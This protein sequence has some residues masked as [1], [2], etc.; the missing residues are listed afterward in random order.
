MAAHGRGGRGVLHDV[1]Q[2]GAGAGQQADGHQR[3]QRVVHRTAGR[4]P[5]GEGTRGLAGQGCGDH[6]PPVLPGESHDR[7]AGGQAPGVPAGR[8]KVLGDLRQTPRQEGRHVLHCQELT[9][10][11]ESIQSG[12]IPHP[13]GLQLPEE[14]FG[15]QIPGAGLAIQCR[16]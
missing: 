11:L 4:R 5:P 13:E 12:G 7:R 1:R 14:S 15:P 9:S 8:R 2:S 16:R 3:S 10:P 6:R